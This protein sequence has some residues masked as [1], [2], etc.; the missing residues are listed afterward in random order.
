MK[1]PL[2]MPPKPHNASKSG[3]KVQSPTA[4]GLALA[5]YLCERGVK[6]RQ[7]FLKFLDESGVVGGPKVNRAGTSGGI[8]ASDLFTDEPT[9]EFLGCL[10]AMIAADQDPDAFGWSQRHGGGPLAS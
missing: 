7:E 8:A 4:S 6:A 1:A 5:V 3:A 2:A 9:K 10:A